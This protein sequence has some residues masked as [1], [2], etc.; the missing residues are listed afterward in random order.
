MYRDFTKRIETDNNKI[1]NVFESDFYSVLKRKYEKVT[2]LQTGTDIDKQEG[3][4]ITYR[5]IR[6]DCTTDFAMKDFMPAIY[7]TNI[8][9]TRTQKFMIGIRIGNSYKGYTEFQQPTVVI[10]VNMNGH[11]YNI[12][13]DELL[14]N[15]E[16]HIEE[17]MMAAGDAYEDFITIEEREELFTAP[18]KINPRYPQNITS[19]RYQQAIERL[20]MENTQTIYNEEEL[21]G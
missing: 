1:G 13:E 11:D 18:L 6:I 8:P 15:L 14:D 4:D 2:C 12:H 21:G 5:D 20:R 17:L 7:E 10:G 9:A 19:L 16:A 3:T